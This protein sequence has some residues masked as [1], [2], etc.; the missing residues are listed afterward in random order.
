[1]LMLF[2]LAVPL[3]ALAAIFALRPAR[4]LDLVVGEIVAFVFSSGAAGLGI[5]AIAAALVGWLA[6]PRAG[7]GTGGFGRLGRGLL[8]FDAFTLLCGIA[9]EIAGLEAAE[10]AAL[11][12]AKAQV[13]GAYGAWFWGGTGL[14]MLACF[15]LWRGA[16]RTGLRPRTVVFAGAL[17]VAAVFLQ[18]YVLLVA[19]QTH[20]LSLPYPPG[21]YSPSGIEL[22]VS[23]GIVALSLLLLL[24]AAR[25]IPFAP[26]VYDDRSVV[27]GRTDLRRALVVASWLALGLAATASGLILSW[28]GGTQSFLDP[29]LPASPVLFIAGLCVLTT[30]GAVYELLPE[31]AADTSLSP[32]PPSLGA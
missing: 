20:G 2:L 27:A 29:L 18:R 5:L 25:L 11:A 16:W 24:P 32:P 9:V 17:S 26:V 4:P 22:S 21:S 28:R 1:M 6:G 8:F 14:L 13:A 15:V 31:R 12:F 23:A 30:A 19:W 10:P 3:C 7:L